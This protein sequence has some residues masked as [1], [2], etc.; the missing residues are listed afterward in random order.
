MKT[1]ADSKKKDYEKSARKAVEW[2]IE[3]LESPIDTSDLKESR[4]K[5][6][7]QSKEKAHLALISIAE[8]SMI[9]DEY[10]EKCINA[11][12]VAW[13]ELNKVLGEAYPVSDVD[14][15]DG[16]IAEG[17]K[18]DILKSVCESKEY[19]NQILPKISQTIDGWGDDEEILKMALKKKEQDLTVIQKLTKN[20]D[21]R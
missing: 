9:F 20:I 15:G 1:H 21:L 3:V 10:K 18:P 14:L 12:D 7:C 6:A 2:L 16:E 11:L 8:K 17:L 5:M 4:L 19:I 13:S